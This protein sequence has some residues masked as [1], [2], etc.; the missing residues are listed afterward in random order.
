MLALLRFARG[1]PRRLVQPVAKERLVHPVAKE[2]LF[3]PV[4][5]KRNCF[6]Q[7]V[8][9]AFWVYLFCSSFGLTRLALRHGIFAGD[10][11]SCLTPSGP[12]EGVRGRLLQ[13][14]APCL[15]V[16]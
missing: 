15:M 1:L 9:P 14:K 4:A 6:L 2:R 16:P 12:K 3:Q 13:G 8:Q 10:S 7:F 11:G 5:K